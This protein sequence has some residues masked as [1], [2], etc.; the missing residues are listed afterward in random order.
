MK[1]VTSLASKGKTKKN[2]ISLWLSIL[3]SL[4]L[5]SQRAVSDPLI[6][7]FGSHNAAPYAFVENNQL[8]S[9]IIK[10]IA[11]VLA[12]KLGIDVVYKAVPRK[13]M[14]DY[15]GSGKIHAI[16]IVNPIWINNSEKYQ[17]THPLFQES[18]IFVVSSNNNFS[19]TSYKDLHGKRLGAI[20]GYIYNTLTEH[21]QAGKIIRDDVA[22]IDTNFRK[23]NAG[24]I[25]ALIDSDIMINF[26]LKNNQVNQKFIIAD[27]VASTH[28][29]YAMFA[30]KLPVPFIRINE[31]LSQLKQSGQIE[32][33]LNRY[34]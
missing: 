23:L 15:L 6:V 13:R 31:A 3:F 32:A 12:K 1:N 24:R 29:I 28:D 33:I 21:F 14:V 9:G 20:S 26:Y 10:D 27:K 2:I 16:F 8:R 7:S 30:Q 11:D 5:F 25:D 22:D 19:I 17:W 34:K 18:D 4:C